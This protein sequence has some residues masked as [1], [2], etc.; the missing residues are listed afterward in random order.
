LSLSPAALYGVLDGSDRCHEACE[1][2]YTKVRVLQRKKE[3]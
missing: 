3:G 2:F 1:S